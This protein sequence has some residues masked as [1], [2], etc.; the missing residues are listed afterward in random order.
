MFKKVF[1]VVT[2]RAHR[3]YWPTVIIFWGYVLY[4]F[5]N[6]VDLVPVFGH[7]DF[8]IDYVHEL[9]WMSAGLLVPFQLLSIVFGTPV[10]FISQIMGAPLLG[11][12]SAAYGVPEVF[13]YMLLYVYEIFI[14]SAII[15]LI[16][17][18]NWAVLR[19]IASVKNKA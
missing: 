13:V 15:A 16:F 7:F 19:F 6:F 12:V 11:Y 4:F 10:Y 2:F 1:R 8:N 17:L 18:C 5:S 9:Y 3:E 14:I